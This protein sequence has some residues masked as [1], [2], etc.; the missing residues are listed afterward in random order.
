MNSWIFQANPDRFDIDAYMR[1]GAPLL[2][3]VNQHRDRIGDGDAVYLY[4]CKG[5]SGRDGGFVGRARVLGVPF[6]RE[7]EE[8]A[9]HLWTDPADAGRRATRVWLLLESKW[10]GEAPLSREAMMND[11]VGRTLRN[12]PN[13]QGTNFELNQDQAIW[14]SERWTGLP[15]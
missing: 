12:L 11:D 13:G 6:E 3:L 7:D 5:H 9:R 14:L 10:N 1:V 15:R 4:R 8:S 2:W